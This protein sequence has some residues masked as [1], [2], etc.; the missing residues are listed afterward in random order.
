MIL[1]IHEAETAL[2][3]IKEE[4]EKIAEYHNHNRACVFKAFMDAEILTRKMAVSFIKHIAVYEKGRIE[5]FF[6]YCNS[7]N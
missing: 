7:Y 2:L 4:I 3:T 1:K 5:V 6:R